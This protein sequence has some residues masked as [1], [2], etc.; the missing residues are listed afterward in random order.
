MGDVSSN[1]RKGAREHSLARVLM[2]TALGVTAAAAAFGAPSAAAQ[3]TEAEETQRTITVVGRRGEN[4]VA[5]PKNTAPILDTPQTIQVIPQAVFDQQGA[6]NLTDVL[7][8][9]PGITFNAGENGFSSGPANFSMRG[10]DTSAH[11]FADGARDSGSFSRD[12]FNIEQVEVVKGPAGDNGRGGAGGYVNIVTK[13]P[14][15]EAAYSASFSYGF[16]DYNSEDRTRTT[17]DLNQPLS[18]T[19][20]AR[21]NVL[22]EDGG[23]PG[24]DVASRYSFGFAPSIAFGLGPPTQVTFGGQVVLQE[25]TPD[26]GIPA[27][28]VDGMREHELIYALPAGLDPEDFRDVYYGFASDYDDTESAVALARLE[29]RFSPALDVSSQLRWSRTDRESAFGIV[30]QLAPNQTTVPGVPV[31]PT[32]VAVQRIGYARENQSLSWL[33]NFTASFETGAARHRLAFGVDVSLEEADARAFSPPAAVTTPISTAPN[34]DRA[35][36]ALTLTERSHVEVNSIAAYLYDTIELSPQWELTGGL[37]VES[38]EVDIESATIGG[39]PTSANGLSISETTLAG[40]IGLVHKPAPNAS[41]YGS[42]GIAPLPPASFLSTT[43]ISRGG[44]NGFPGFESGMNSEES[45]VQE[46]INYEI[47]AK[48]D[49]FGERLSLT[50]ALFRTER[51]NVAITGRTGVT[52]ADPISLLGY[53]EQIVQGLELGVSGEIT[54]QWSVFGGALFMESERQHSAELDLYR[55]RAQPGDYGLANSNVGI[56]ACDAALHGTNGDALAF[57]PEVS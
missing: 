18:P 41:I 31:T 53:G 32:G 39:V 7:R 44:A 25:D 29:H 27:V 9:T 4:E 36:G 55:C 5:S 10:F 30:T 22:Y 43:D 12:A 57:T 16:D 17:L 20:A 21:L 42:V 1:E 50:S 46:S 51:Q 8:N 49:L 23:V 45:D 24:R 56:A 54:P 38:Y 13:S 3:E 28:F 15:D 11:I 48:W 34:P 6:R 47:G 14:H 2:S 19:A 40:R 26:W 33:N 52:T 35:G 37:R